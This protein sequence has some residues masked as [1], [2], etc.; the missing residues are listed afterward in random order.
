[1]TPTSASTDIESRARERVDLKIGLYTHAL[2]YVCVN[3]GLFV[4]NMA[5]TSTRWSFWPLFGWGI[6]L[7]IHAIVVVVSLR[8]EGLRQR[9]LADEIET[10]RRRNPDA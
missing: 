8:G 9:M 10:L 7:A 3:L 2:V 4:L 1:M 5:T 6:G